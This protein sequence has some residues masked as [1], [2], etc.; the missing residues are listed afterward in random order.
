MS[1][2]PTDLAAA[3]VMGFRAIGRP[4]CTGSIRTVAELTRGKHAVV[5]ADADAPGQRGAQALAVAMVP[6]VLSVRT[7]TPPHPMKDLRAWLR[8]GATAADVQSLIDSTVART[9]RVRIRM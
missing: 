7:I 3:V 9:L 1:E 2:G 4:T 5:V 8:A 6:F